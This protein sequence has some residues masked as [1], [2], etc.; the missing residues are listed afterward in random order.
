MASRRTSTVSLARHLLNVVREVNEWRREH[1]A[2]V[3]MQH[4]EE[5]RP[6]WS[7]RTEAPRRRPSE[8]GRSDGA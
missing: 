2:F 8:L 6:S 5:M 1:E 7:A 3:A 4:L